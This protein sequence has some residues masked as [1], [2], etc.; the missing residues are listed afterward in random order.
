MSMPVDAGKTTERMQ[1]HTHD[2]DIATH[3]ASTSSQLTGRNANVTTS[4]P[5]SSVR[6]G[7]NVSSISMPIVEH[8]GIRLREPR[9]HFHF[10][11]K[12]DVADAERH[13]RLPVGPEYGGDGGGKSCVVHA[14]SR[15]RRANRCSSIAVDAQR[16]H[17]P[18]A[19]NVTMPHAVQRLPIN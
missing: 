19:G 2:R 4:L 1:P 14:Q 12:L 6:N 17:E 9:L 5:S 13:E 8:V 7:T 11:G 16:G 10:A 18:W 15:P 3:A